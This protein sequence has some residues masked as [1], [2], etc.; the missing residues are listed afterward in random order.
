MSFYKPIH[1]ADG[2]DEI[3]FFDETRHA[4]RSYVER[5]VTRDITGDPVLHP[6]AK[7]SFFRS[8]EAMMKERQVQERG[9]FPPQHVRFYFINRV[10]ARRWPQPVNR[11][12]TVL[13]VYLCRPPH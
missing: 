9:R 4:A 10:P 6:I 11:N 5:V 12:P 7:Q 2:T 13:T 1:N 3:G 8:S